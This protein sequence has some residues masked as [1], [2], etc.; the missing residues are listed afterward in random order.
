MVMKSSNVSGIGHQVEYDMRTISA[1]R[2]LLQ[3]AY[4]MLEGTRARE[5]Q[6]K[7]FDLMNEADELRGS[8]EEMLNLDY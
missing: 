5:L 1:A 3:E 2:Q 4:E 7:I 6:K 8:A